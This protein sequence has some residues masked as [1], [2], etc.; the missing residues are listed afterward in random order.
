MSEDGFSAAVA[1]GVIGA[2][3]AYGSLLRSIVEVARAIFSAQRS[4][5]F[6]LDEEA[7]ELVFEALAGEEEQ[8]LIGTR[9]PSSTGHRRLDARHPAAARDRGPDAG[10]AAL[11][12]GRREDRLR[13]EGDHVGAAAR[14][15]A[16][17]RRAPGARP[18]AAA[19]ASRSRR[20]SCS[21]SSRT[22]RRS[23]ST[24][25][26][27]RAARRPRS[28]SG[29][30]DVAVVARL[31][32][33]LDALDEDRPRAGAAR[34]SRRSRTCSS[35]EKG[36]LRRPSQTAVARRLVVLATCS[37]CSNCAPRR[38]LLLAACSTVL[39]AGGPRRRASSC[40]RSTSSLRDGAPRRPCCRPSCSLWSR[41]SRSPFACSRLPP[42]T[43]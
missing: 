18:A 8:G 36:A 4:S 20:W 10:P 14:R 34:C 35:N 7:D 16:R 22:R 32:A 27:A 1:A 17:A 31:A 25:C 21:G 6:L 9:I 19:R 29:S 33:A 26:S 30:G 11:A 15:G 41:H 38:R 43:D 13:A 40:S 24:C 42:S 12:R 2:E 37:T 5:I 3:D 39:E 23:R 28:S